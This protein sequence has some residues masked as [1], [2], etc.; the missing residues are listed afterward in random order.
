MKSKEILIEVKE[1]PASW[2]WLLTLGVLNLLF[3]A[4]GI[5]IAGLVTITTTILFGIL[6]FLSGVLQTYHWFKEKDASWS[7]RIPHL[8]FA[9][10]YLAGGVVIFIDPISGASALTIMLAVVFI[11]I[12]ALRLGL[13]TLLAIHGWRWLQHAIGGILALVLGIYILIN[14]PISSLWVIGLLISV[15]MILNGWQMIIVALKTKKLEKNS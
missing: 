12:G 10:L 9:L 13:S 4:I 2:K 14:W 1:L 3:G 5:S 11:L 6:M 8:I 15:E 7:G